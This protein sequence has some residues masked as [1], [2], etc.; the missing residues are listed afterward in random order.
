MFTNG[1]HGV[2][3]TIDGISRGAG[4][5]GNPGSLAG[6]ISRY[7]DQLG[8]LAGDQAKL[9]EQQETLRARLATRFIAS[10][11]RIGAAKST[12]SFLQNQIA[13]WNSQKS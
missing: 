5:V 4:Q 9:A 10:E 7:T 13:A 8:K 6:S 1:L 11:N 2:F 3:G 12:L